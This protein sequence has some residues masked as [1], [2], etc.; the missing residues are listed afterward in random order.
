MPNSHF[1]PTADDKAVTLRR[2]EKADLGSVMALERLPG[3]EALVGRSPRADHEEMLSS[4]RHAYLLGFLDA[5][6]PFAF[7][8]LRDLDNAHG[9]VYLQRVAVD[10]PGQGRG[11]RFLTAVVDWTFAETS[12]HRFYLDCFLENARARRA[13][14]KLGLTHDGNL[15][16]AYLASD[17]TRRDLALMAITRPEWTARRKAG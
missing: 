11:T 13:Y 10:S 15:R 17:G 5:P 2:A 8:M 12:A 7:A 16:E 3:Y 6:A 9:N 1:F 4:G 14:A